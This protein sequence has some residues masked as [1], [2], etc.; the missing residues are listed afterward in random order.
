MRKLCLII[1]WSW[2]IVAT[3]FAQESTVLDLEKALQLGLER[4]FGVKIAVNQVKLAEIERKAAAGDSFLPQVT[5]TYTQT[6]S[7]EDVTQ[8]FATSTTENRILDAKSDVE[9]FTISAIYGFRPETIFTVQ[10]LGK[11]MEISELDAKVV[12]ENTVAAISTA[13]FRLVLELQRAGV[14]QKTLEFS[15]ARLGIAEARYELGGAGRRDFLTAQVDYNSDLSS[16]TNQ[17]QVIQNARIN[18]NELLALDPEVVFEV[19]D[20][21]LIDQHLILEDLLEN[22]YLQNKAFLISQ[23]LEN[24]AF[25]QIRELHASRLPGLNL[26]GAYS[27]NTFNSEAGFLLKNQREGYNYGANISFNLFNGFVIN[28]RVQA[29]KVNKYNA[30]LNLMQFE[31]QMKSDLHRAYNT[32]LNNK[33]LLEIERK[34]YEVAVENT[35]IALERFKLGIANYLEFRDAQVNLLAAENRLIEVLYNIKER[36]IELMRLSGKIFFRD[37]SERIVN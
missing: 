20:T 21:I 8:Q 23:R 34:N 5:T 12:V 27:N 25:L 22:A 32:Y 1:F 7:E 16:V 9:N 33:N 28:R 2:G 15:K 17:Q 18:L 13:Y 24:V 19:K 29:A 3:G 35:D 26:T 10:R 11:L 30:E 14:F 36:E 31:N 6:Y 37:A 4:N